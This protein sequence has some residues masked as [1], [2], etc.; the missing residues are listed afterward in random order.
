VSCSW[1]ALE[2]EKEF[3]VPASFDDAEAWFRTACSLAHSPIAPKIAVVLRDP[4]ADVE[5]DAALRQVECQLQSL[6]GEVPLTGSWADAARARLVREGEELRAE[7]D[8]QKELYETEVNKHRAAFHSASREKAVAAEDVG[9]NDDAT[10][11][12]DQAMRVQD[13]LQSEQSELEKVTT[14]VQN[15]RQEIVEVRVHTACIEHRAFAAEKEKEETLRLFSASHTRLKF[16]RAQLE[17][18]EKRVEDLRQQILELRGMQTP[19]S[20]PSSPRSEDPPSALGEGEL[21]EPPSM[22]STPQVSAREMPADT[23]EVT[24]NDSPRR[25]TNGT[26]RLSRAGFDVGSDKGVV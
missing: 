23:L 26:S 20:A 6:H 14:E 25:A 12:V 21:R 22:Q 13:Q 17:E 1:V 5:V 19:P 7:F 9:D 8:R 24:P 4:E 10:A 11:E 15:L 2:A 3:V 18:G 16:M